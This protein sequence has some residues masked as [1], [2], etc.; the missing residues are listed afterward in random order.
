MLLKGP[1]T[2]VADSGSAYVIDRGDQRLATAGSGDVLTGI[3]A[4]ALAGG[5]DPVRSVAAAAW[6]HADAGRRG[7]PVGMVAGDLVDML[8]AVFAD[9]VGDGD[10]GVA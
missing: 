7:A 5:G 8:P 3:I 2:V 10:G 4:A 1:T 9:C 6:V